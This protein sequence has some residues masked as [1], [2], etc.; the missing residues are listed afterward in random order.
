MKEVF[1]KTPQKKKSTP[2]AECEGELYV[3]AE[4]A[5]MHFLCLMYDGIEVAF[6][7]GNKTPYL[8]ID[9][10]IQWHENEIKATDG[11]WGRKFLD[12]LLEAKKNFLEDR[13]AS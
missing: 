6:F 4:Y 11:K 2:F 3:K 10:A 7:G 9:N 13:K 12:A 1:M 5:G 8:K